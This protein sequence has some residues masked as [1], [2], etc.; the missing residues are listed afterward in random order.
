M[1]DFDD[2]AVGEDINYATTDTTEWSDF[3]EIVEEIPL[4]SDSASET[5]DFDSTE[6]EK[7]AEYARSFGFDK[8]ADYIERHYDGDV[9]VPGEPIPITTRNMGLDG[10]VSDNGVPFE[11]RTA[12][13]SE[14]LT[15][16]GVFPDFES[17]HHVELGSEAKDMSLHQQFSAC[18]ADFQDHMYDD[19]DI[20]DGI[21]FEAME[22]MDS[23]Q[24]YTPEGF[25]WQ[26]N[27]ETGS[28]DL[29]SQ[30]DHAVGHTGGNALWGC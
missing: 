7:A 23:P 17:R 27:P 2:V 22:R 25:T 24:G 28:F 18:R 9:F 1:N 6:A 15:V 21:T 3:D 20:L 16:E 26:H 8:A 11:R 14:G 12:D 10:D 30:E 19:P 5:T 29:V 4:V 13:L